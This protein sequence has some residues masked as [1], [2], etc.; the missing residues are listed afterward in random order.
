MDFI[1]GAFGWI[2][3]SFV[4]YAVANNKGRSGCA[5]FFISLL[6]SPLI[7]FI[8]LLCVGDSDEKKEESLK[9]AMDVIERARTNDDDEDM[10]QDK[11][12]EE[13]QKAKKLLD[14]EVITQDEY[15][16]KKAELM[17]FLR[18]DLLNPK[19]VEE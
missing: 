18:N 12:I 3:L 16:A 10:N 7:A 14:L 15:D 8:V 11:A 5:W 13:L 1:F 19:V 9:K 17:P 2:I 4:V 6:L